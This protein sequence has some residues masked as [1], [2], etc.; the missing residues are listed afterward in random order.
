MKRIVVLATVA[1]GIVVVGVL[2][3]YGPAQGQGNGN[4][5]VQRGFAIAPVPLNLQGKNHDLVGL[6][7]YIVNAQGACNECHT[8]P[9]FSPGHNPFP[10]PAG[11]SGDGQINSVNYMAGGVD[12]G[13][14]VSKNLTPDSAGKPA[15]LTLAQFIAAMRTGHDPIEN[16]TLTIMPWPIYGK[17]TDRDLEAIYTYLT[18]IPPATPGSCPFGSGQ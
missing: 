13:L 14:A 3:S 7:S 16:D 11:V 15:G 6:G 4:R 17:M 2:A 12:F 9:S 1:V 10:P 18:A 5:E 8:C